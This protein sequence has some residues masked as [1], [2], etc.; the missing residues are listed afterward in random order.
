VLVSGAT[1]LIG[2]RLVPGLLRDGVQVR[3]LS[4]RP[5]APP[6]QH[7][8]RYRAWDGLRVPPEALAGA[9]AVVHL[10]GEPVFGGLLTRRRRRRIRESRVDSTHSFVD[11][12]AA[13]PAGE[14]PGVF[15]CA[16][17][18]GI[19]GSRGDELL[20]EASRPGEGF[21]AELCRD[22]E[23]AARRAEEHGVRTV[24]LRLGIVLAR[25]GGA[26]AMLRLLF[27]AGLGGRLGD[28][29]QWVPWIHVDDAVGL[30]RLALDDEGLRGPVNGVAPEPVRN[31]E[32]TRA[33]A[34]ALGRPSFLAV[35]GVALRAAL[36][37]LSGELL[38][39][40]RATPRAALARGYAFVHPRLDAA[41]RAELD[42][43]LSGEPGSR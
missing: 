9:E 17:A 38:S 40:R 19:Y 8:P 33:L 20:D 1:G 27:R 21:L 2:S 10:A 6:P 16:S 25:T 18:V 5:P 39:S 41:L 35:P 42:A 12:M 43:A 37:E 13:L 3:A 23:D 26:L 32:L 7:G 14:R 11:A 31:A 15:V 28:G 4:R 34:A 22:W 36:G 29:R 30:I 24:S